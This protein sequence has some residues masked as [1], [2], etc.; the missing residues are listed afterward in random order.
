MF[1]PLIKVISVEYDH[2]GISN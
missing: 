2:H 1:D